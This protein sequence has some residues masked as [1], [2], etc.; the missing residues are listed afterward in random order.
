MSSKNKAMDIPRHGGNLDV[1]IR[2]LGGTAEDWVDLSTGISPW[3]YPIPEL[4]DDLWREL[5]PSSEALVRIAADYYQTQVDRIC[6]T[7]GS[8]LAIRILPSLIQHQRVA[9]PLIGYQEHRYAWEKAK[10]TVILYRDFGQLKHLLKSDKVDSALLINPNNPSNELIAKE[11]VLKLA[12]SL[13]GLLVVDEAFAD[14][15]G[16]LITE[17]SNSVSSNSEYDNLIVIRSVGKFF[18]L[19]GARIGF[20][21]GGHNIVHQLKMLFTPWCINAPAQFIAQAALADT[22][23]QNQ[24]AARIKQQ[25]AELDAFLQAF[26][27]KNSLDLECRSNG[28]FTSLFGCDSIIKLLHQFLSKNQIWTRI[29]DTFTSTLEPNKEPQ[30]WLRL[31]L[32]GDHFNRLQNTLNTF[33]SK[34]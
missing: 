5:P 15:K 8:Q 34:P 29:G 31:S 14:F 18:G 7:P 26:I 9:I 23:W 6:P 16:C 13:S 33:N 28:L 11:D 32:P 20:L 17:D 3:V 1:A 27:Q 19:A 2:Q 12:K 25:S 22:K 10:H 24:Q 21:I 30:N 4:A